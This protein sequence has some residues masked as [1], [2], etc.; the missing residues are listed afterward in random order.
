MKKFVLFLFLFL[1]CLFDV[2]SQ[3][4][5]EILELEISDIK[6]QEK[7]NRG[8]ENEGEGPYIHIKCSMSNEMVKAICILP[9]KS[10]LELCFNYNENYYTVYGQS[11]AFH[12]RDSVILNQNEKVEFEIGSRLLLGTK[13]WDEKR[14][15]YSMILLGLL[16][17]LT[18]NYKDPN[19][20]FIT[21][22]INKVKIKQ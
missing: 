16:P 20:N 8:S 21:T 2:Y 7:N 5:F 9:S 12:D 6:Y 15:D 18:V 1:V 22:K 10:K 3:L 4:K 13:L 17:T 19:F 11:I 14:K